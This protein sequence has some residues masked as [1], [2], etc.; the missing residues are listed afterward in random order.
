[1]ARKVGLVG[2]RAV[3]E[4]PRFEARSGWQNQVARGID[5]VVTLQEVIERVQAA[6]GHRPEHSWIPTLP[7]NFRDLPL[8]R[9]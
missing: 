5:R 3:G 2:N 4:V 1:M 9:P 8:V 7:L 6:Q